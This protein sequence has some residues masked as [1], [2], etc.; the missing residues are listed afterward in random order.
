MRALHLAGDLAG[1]ARHL[2]Q[3]QGARIDLVHCG[4]GVP[5]DAHRMQA[6]VRERRAEGAELPAGL[7]LPLRVG[8]SSAISRLEAVGE[9]SLEVGQVGRTQ[10]ASEVARRDRGIAREDADAEAHG[11]VLARALGVAVLRGG[12]LA[13]DDLQANIGVA[14]MRSGARGDEIT[15]EG[16]DA[17]D[18]VRVDGGGHGRYRG[19]KGST[20]TVSPVR[21]SPRSSSITMKQFAAV[22]DVRMPEPCGP[23]VRTSQWSCAQER[24][25]RLNSRRLTFLLSGSAAVA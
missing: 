6:R 19:W 2:A 7:R 4:Y 3:L 18:Q 20:Q 15:H 17:L 9:D 5:A 25:P 24:I 21:M 11:R 12:V 13:L 10:T 1:E 8:E 14:Q 16:G 23:V 22:I